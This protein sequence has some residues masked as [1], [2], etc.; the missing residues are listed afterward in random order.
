[1]TRTA[2]ELERVEAAFA[3]GCP[4]LALFGWPPILALAAWAEAHRDDIASDLSVF[5]RVD[6][7]ETMPS[8]LYFERAVRLGSYKGV[9]GQQLEAEAIEEAQ[10]SSPGPTPARRAEKP[11]VLPEAVAL[12]ELEREG[13]I[14][15]RRGKAAA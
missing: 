7:W 9:I 2:E 10:S 11:K 4:L 12:A 8:A 13:F 1:M 14:R 3:E 6:D 15:H 5:H